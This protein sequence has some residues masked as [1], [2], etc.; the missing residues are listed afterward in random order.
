[1]QFSDIV[2]GQVFFEGITGEYYVKTGAT[3][4]LVYD[5]GKLC[6]YQDRDGYMECRFIPTHLVEVEE[7]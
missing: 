1:M 3:T 2:I 6:V 7:V 4:A 5:M